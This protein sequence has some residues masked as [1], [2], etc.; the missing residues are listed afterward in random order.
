MKPDKPVTVWIQDRPGRS[1]TLEWNDPKTGK[2][3]QRSAE[4]DDYAVAEDQKKA[5][6]YELNHGLYRDVSRMTWDDFR[7]KVREERSVHLRDRA[8]EKIETV[9]DAFEEFCAP[10]R[11]ADVDESMVSKFAAKLRTEKN[12]KGRQFA[13]WS[14][15]NYLGALRAVMRWAAK[16]KWTE[17]PTFPTISVAK[18]FPKPVPGEAFERLLDAMPDDRWRALLLC[19]WWA[20]LRLNESLHLCRRPSGDNP[21]VDW[22]AD[23]IIL[24]PPA[25]KSG[26]DQAVPLARTL[27]KALEKLP[28]DGDRLFNIISKKTGRQI[29]RGGV[30]ENVTFFAR[31]AGVKLSMH[32]LR[33]GFG[34]RLADRVQPQV[35][36]RAMRHSDVKTTM[37]FYANVDEA[38]KAAIK[39]L[40]EGLTPRRRPVSRGASRGAAS[41]KRKRKSA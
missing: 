17:C 33:K 24:P 10:K 37:D 6:E 7:Q 34:S 25:N 39:E 3:R 30:S 2:R 14:I 4:T 15:K 21:Y 12:K 27:R 20:G 38:V 8:A 26:D 22:E 18:R 36:Q 23:M 1:L 40:D 29:T 35:L 19:G 32:K 31:R 9:L 11:L 16:M 41:D 5:L 13:D 28:D